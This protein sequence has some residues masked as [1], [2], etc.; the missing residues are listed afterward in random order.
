MPTKKN[1]RIPVV[2]HDPVSVELTE[3]LM[4]ASWRGPSQRE[5]SDQRD[6][7]GKSPERKESNPK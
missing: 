5:Q 2:P 3:E 4:P 1:D 7:F 6:K